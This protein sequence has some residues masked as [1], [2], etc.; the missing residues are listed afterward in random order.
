MNDI[1]TVEKGIIAVAAGTISYVATSMLLR[2]FLEEYGQIQLA[3]IILI[4]LAIIYIS[5]PRGG[6][7]K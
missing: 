1:F 2:D 7:D 5:I 6:D 3:A 4:C